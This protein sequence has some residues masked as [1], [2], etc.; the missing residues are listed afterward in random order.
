M[1]QALRKAHFAVALN[2]RTPYVGRANTFSSKSIQECRRSICFLSPIDGAPLP[3][4]YAHA[5]SR[6]RARALEKAARGSIIKTSAYLS[7]SLCL[8]SIA[9]IISLAFECHRLT[10]RREEMRTATIPH[11]SHGAQSPSRSLSVVP[12]SPL[13]TLFFFHLLSH[14]R[15]LASLSLEEKKKNSDLAEVLPRCITRN[16]RKTTSTRSRTIPRFSV[17]PPPSLLTPRLAATLLRR[18]VER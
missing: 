11:S 10:G 2:A 12:Y 4:Q 9:I 15:S 1:Q 16:G 13:Y 3:T 5:S 17:S 7:F 18:E 14:L 8:G 6:N